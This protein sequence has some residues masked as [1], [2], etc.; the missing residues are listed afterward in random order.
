[1]CIIWILYAKT[2]RDTSFFGRCFEIVSSQDID[3]GYGDV[4]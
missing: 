4:P 1:M 3:I 2:M